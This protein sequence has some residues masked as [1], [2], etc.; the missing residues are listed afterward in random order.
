MRKCVSL[1]VLNICL[2]VVREELQNNCLPK[3]IPPR[4]TAEVSD[5]LEKKKKRYPGP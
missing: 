3:D 1:E 2:S 5:L 4:L